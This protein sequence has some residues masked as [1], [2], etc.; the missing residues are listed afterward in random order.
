MPEQLRDGNNSL[1]ELGFLWQSFILVWLFLW[2]NKNRFGIFLSLKKVAAMYFHAHDVNSISWSSC[3]RPIQTSPAKN[4][5]QKKRLFEDIWRCKEVGFGWILVVRLHAPVLTF[6]TLLC[7]PF[8]FKEGISSNCHR[9]KCI[10][11]W[12]KCRSFDQQDEKL[13]KSRTFYPLLSLH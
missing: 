6:L 10:Y 11:M 13:G 7:L 3:C 9:K 1:V 4:F 12:K 2:R 5:S 8:S